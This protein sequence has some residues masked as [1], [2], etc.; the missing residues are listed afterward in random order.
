MCD[1]QVAVTTFAAG[2]TITDAGP[3]TTIPSTILQSSSA[4]ATPLLSTSIASTFVPTTT[5]EPVVPSTSIVTTTLQSAPGLST[6][7]PSTVIVSTTVP[8][9]PSTSEV[10]ATSHLTIEQTS[11]TSAATSGSTFTGRAVMAPVRICSELYAVIALAASHMF[12]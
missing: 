3:S 2:T 5:I 7:P 1:G 12:P 8:F 11:P 9:V 4:P 6:P 10:P